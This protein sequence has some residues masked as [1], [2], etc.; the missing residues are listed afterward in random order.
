MRR[1]GL[2]LLSLIVAGVCV[3]LGI[4]QVSRL[5]ERRA[6]NAELSARMAQIPLDLDGALPDSLTWRHAIARGIYDYDHE[7]LLANRTQGGLPGAYVVTPLRL[8]SGR[9]VLVERGWM[10]APDGRD[11]GHIPI[12]P[13]DTAVSGVIVE[14]LG[15]QT[16]RIEDVNPKYHWPMTVQTL[17]L[18]A[19]A[20]PLGLV[21]AVLRRTSG[22]SMPMQTIPTPALDDGPHLS[23]AIQW[24]SF[25][26][27]AL[28]GGWVVWRRRDS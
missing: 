14:Q 18:W 21:T 1:Y 10:Y 6:W 28:V 16:P 26:L 24:F 15:K 20:K 19:L 12:E 25:A 27:I 9:L 13:A 4:W 2:P 23:Y 17:D 8:R 11:V 22:G 7:I 3:R 5:K